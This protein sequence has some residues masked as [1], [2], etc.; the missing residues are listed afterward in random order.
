MKLEQYLDSTYLKTS[1]QVNISSE[2]T[3]EILKNLADEAIAY[4]MF[5]IMIRPDFV[6]AMRAYL[7]SK[8]SEVKLG[9]VIGFPEGT[10]SVHEKLAES[11]RA[12]KDGADELDFVIN[13][14]A[15][16]Q[17]KIDLVETEFVK[18]TQLALEHQKI[19]KWII[20]I[21]A[22]STQQIAEISEKISTWAH[23]NFQ[24]EQLSNIFV[25]SSTGFYNDGSGRPNGATKEGIEIMLKNAKG[26]PIK[27]AGGVKTYDEAV[28]MINLGVKRIGTSS[29]RA[30]LSNE[31]SGE[32][33]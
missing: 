31:K 9:T 4:H 19:A 12:I 2:E 10:F 24:A 6:K 25:K 23:Q 32:S 22:L 3:W 28:E 14:D 33:Y 1:A 17:G 5:A 20:E 27:A 18:C 30:L 11:Q 16:K 8:H 13:Y 21:A 26:L 15:F 7:D 29:A